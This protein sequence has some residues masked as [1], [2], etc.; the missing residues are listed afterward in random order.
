MMITEY[1]KM[2]CDCT[3][4]AKHAEKKKEREEFQFFFLLHQNLIPA[5]KSV[6][7]FFFVEKIKY[8]LI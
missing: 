4:L 7:V 5:I 1:S 3:E 2:K 8:N 6:H